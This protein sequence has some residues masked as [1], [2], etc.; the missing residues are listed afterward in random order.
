VKNRNAVAGFA[1]PT[2]I[3]LLVI[4]AALGAF[5]LSV[6]TAQHTGAALDLQGERAYQAA[7]AG[8]EW[9]LFQSLR[10]ASCG[11]ATLTFGGTGL[12]SFTTVVSCASTTTTELSR[13]VT[14]DRIT[15][16]ACNQAPCPNPAPGMS[17]VERQVSVSVQ[18][19]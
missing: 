17:Y 7:T 3:F 2:A 11:N 14:I 9:G 13:T 18:R 5:L 4:L 15:A 12:Q 16:T 6:S 8:A 10:N 1:L 19:P